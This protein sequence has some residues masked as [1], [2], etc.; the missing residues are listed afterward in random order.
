MEFDFDEMV[1]IECYK[2]MTST[3]VP[4]PIGFITTVGEDGVVN[5]APYSFFNG[6]CS[7][8][9]IVVFGMEVHPGF[10]PQQDTRENLRHCSEFVANLVSE[11]IVEQMNMCSMNFPPDVD[12]LAETGLTAVPSTKVTP[13]RIKESPVSFECRKLT[14]MEFGPGNQIVL[15]QIV[16]MHVK[17]EFVMDAEKR[18]IDTPALKLIGR[19]HGTGMYAKTSDLYEMPRPPA[20]ADWIKTKTD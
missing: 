3:I 12:E 5:A 14:A 7:E 13:P 1:R 18:Y 17:D 20:Y 10:A 11:D 9:P 4:R 8:P 15:G 16:H 6:M 19:M 2:L